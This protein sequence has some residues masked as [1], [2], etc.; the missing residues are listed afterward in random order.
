[1]TPKKTELFL[2][3][4]CKRMNV[5]VCRYFMSCVSTRDRRDLLVYFSEFERGGEERFSRVY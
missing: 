1:M 4:D 5:L 2:S 3:N